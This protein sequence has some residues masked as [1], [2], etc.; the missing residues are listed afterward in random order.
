MNESYDVIVL[1]TGLKECILSGLLSTKGKRVL[2]LDRNSYYGAETASLNLT[3]L[4]AMFRPGVEPPKE[5]GHNRDWNV[6]LIPKFIMAN[7]KLVKML[8]H[9]KVT[10][11]LEWKCVDATYVLQFQAGGMFSKAKNMIS[12]VPANEKEALMTPLLGMWEKKNVANFYKFMDQ[13]NEAN[14]MTW[15]DVDVKKQPCEAV[16]KKF[17]L[18][19]NTVDFMGHAVALHEN[20]NYL[21]E[22][23][24][25]TLQKIQLYMESMG[26][27]GDSPFL[28]PVYGLGGLPESFSRLC[29]IHGGTYM[30]NTAVDEIMFENGAVCGVRVGND[31]AKAPLVICDPSYVK[32]QKRTRVAGRVIRAICILDHPIPNT[33]DVSSIQIIL[34]QKQLNRKSGKPC[35]PNHLQMSTSLWSPSLTQYALKISI[36]QSSLPPLSQTTPRLKSLQRKNFSVQS[37]KC[38]SLLVTSMN[39][40]T[41]GRK[42]TCSSLKVTTLPVIS[43]Q[44]TL[45][46]SAFTKE[47]LERNLISTCNS[48]RTMTNDQF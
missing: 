3:N 46:Y 17:S 33:N 44:V 13:Y 8:L 28:Y 6:D 23:A 22:P 31:V 45:M 9:T 21:K 7:G 2:H 39:Q 35:L 10:K 36:L 18:A 38:S 1:G 4:W 14:P 30:L 48:Q 41:T 43:R 37:G 26:K 20:D 16:F 32:E 40:S 15:K 19:E 24:V 12:K 5:Y 25:D 42:R 11:Y 47:L 34:P 29:A 27:Y